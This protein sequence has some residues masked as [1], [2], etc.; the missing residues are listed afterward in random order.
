VTPE[1]QL[2]GL[3]VA[4]EAQQKESAKLISDLRAELVQLS[5][6]RRA[7]EVGAARAAGEGARDALASA[8]AEAAKML[9]ASSTAL[10][11]AA[12]RAELAARRLGWKTVGIVASGS[13]AAVLGVLSVGW[14]ITPSPSEI[15]ALRADKAV[16]E[17]NLADLERR[18]GRIKLTTCGK[19][20]G[21]LCT[22]V[23]ESAG[24]FGESG[25]SFRVLKGY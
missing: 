25:R 3:M 15:T 21:R 20:H 10:V 4:A 17:A 14:Y 11:S 23:D 1:E 8:P 22:E 9:D 12:S 16:L 18:G 2:F 6:T 24:S 19:T 5:T 13:F 7:I